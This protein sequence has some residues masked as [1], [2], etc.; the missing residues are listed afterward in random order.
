MPKRNLNAKLQL[1]WSNS[2]NPIPFPALY[3]ELQEGPL[4]W[5]RLVESA[6]EIV[7]FGSRAQE[8]EKPDSD[9]DLL[10]VGTESVRRI[11]GVHLVW[12]RPDQLFTPEWLGSE[13]A[14]H[15]ATYGIW[16]LGTGTWRKQVFVSPIAVTRKE[17]LLRARIQALVRYADDLY[18]SRRDYYGLRIRRDVQ[19]LLIIRDGG[20]VP[21][22][23]LLDSQWDES[24]S[25]TRW[26]DTCLSL[27][28]RSETV[29]QSWRIVSPVSIARQ[30]VL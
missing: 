19:R 27:G 6:V 5:P 21:S 23:P 15:V 4:P 2:R 7:L 12:I 20:A 25:H 18:A 28:I 3:R 9:W 16:L 1:T 8:C 14:G 17:Q 30:T 24:M 13:L 26:V 29:N 11:G 10:C 22:S